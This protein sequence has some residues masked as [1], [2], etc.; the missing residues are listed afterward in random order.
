MRDQWFRMHTDI[1][2]NRKVRTMPAELFR[3][4]IFMLCVARRNGGVLP[5]IEDLAFELRISVKDTNAMLSR[6]RKYA[7]LDEQDDVISPHD[8]GYWQFD[9]EAV[10]KAKKA[11]AERQQR[12]RDKLKNNTVTDHNEEIN[13]TQNNDIKKRDTGA[14]Q[15]RYFTTAETRDVTPSV[16][17]P[18]RS[19]ARTEQNRTEEE[20]NRTNGGEKT[21]SIVLQ[22]SPDVAAT[23]A[24]AANENGIPKTPIPEIPRPSDAELRIIIEQLE[25]GGFPDEKAAAAIVRNCRIVAPDCTIEEISAFLADKIRAVHEQQPMI[26]SP[27]G[28]LIRTV[29]ECV[30]SVSLKKHRD[31]IRNEQRQTESDESL[32]AIE[33]QKFRRLN[34]RIAADETQTPDDR[35]WARRMLA[36]W[37]PNEAPK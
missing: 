22:D 34:E 25:E 24:V 9:L 18:S 14:P 13:I 20:Q 31:R 21:S 10:V 16:T 36:E 15:S 35:A 17:P 11:A 29:P 5:P 1:L 32:A 6:L 2:N 12:R 27:I 28:F 30:K 8:W 4:W 26:K 23:I 7:L 3:E 19:R 37:L 33:R